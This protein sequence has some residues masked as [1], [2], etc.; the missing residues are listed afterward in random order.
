MV[1]LGGGVIGLATAWYCRKLGHD[2]TVVDRHAATR[3]GCSFGNAGLIVPSH[4][5]PLAAPGV[6]RTALK[7]IWNPKSPLYIRPRASLELAS[8]LW[9]FSRACSTTHLNRAAPLLRD[10]HLASRRLYDELDGELP[11]GFGL[12]PGG[13]LLLC[14]TEHGMTEEAETAELAGRLNVA[15]KTLSPAELKQLEPQIEMD[16]RGGVFYPDDRRISP[17][18][19]MSGLQQELVSRGCRFCWETEWHGFRTEQSVVRAVKTN[20]GEIDADHVAICGGVWSS[21]MARALKLSLPMQAGKGYS[22]TLHDPAPT[23]KTAAL[24][25]EARIA[26]T[27]IESSLRFAGTMEIAGIDQTTSPKRI[28]GIIESVPKFFP[29]LTP[30]CFQAVRPWSGL[31]PC[32][33]DGLPYPGTPCRLEQRRHRNGTR[34]ARNQPGDDIWTVDRSTGRGCAG[35]DRRTGNA[36]TRPVQKML[37]FCAAE[38]H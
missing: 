25:C 11:G 19:L 37:G 12:V 29:E 31:R 17:E 9:R 32:S 24:L 20:A 2:V 22:L 15:A 27:P 10:L 13:L 4:F 21:E 36:L 33:P 18:R 8:W 16:V 14:R 35:P 28:Q 5:V 3:D 6:I 38:S 34:D 30:S 1:I 23:L 7:W 26:V